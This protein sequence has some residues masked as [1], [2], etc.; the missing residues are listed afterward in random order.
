MQLATAA[1]VGGE[2]R[3]AIQRGRMGSNELLAIDGDASESLVGTDIGAPVEETPG[4]TPWPTDDSQETGLLTAGSS[5][6]VSQ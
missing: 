1:A 6:S 2:G 5:V 3:R 4:D